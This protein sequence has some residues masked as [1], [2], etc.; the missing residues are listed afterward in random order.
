VEGRQSEAGGIAQ[1]HGATGPYRLEQEIATRHGCAA[2]GTC[3]RTAKRAGAGAADGKIRTPT[4][5]QAHHHYAFVSLHNRSVRNAPAAVNHCAK[6]MN[7]GE[8]SGLDRQEFRHPGE[9]RK[10][11]SREGGADWIAVRLPFKST[12]GD[13]CE[14]FSERQIARHRCV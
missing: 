2:F 7:P 4:A 9:W 5:I 1:R 8:F 11:R 10:S 14:A 13:R 12:P 3:K 6:Y